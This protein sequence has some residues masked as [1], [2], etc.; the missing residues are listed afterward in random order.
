MKKRRL[1]AAMD[2]MSPSAD[3]FERAHELEVDVLLAVSAHAVAGQSLTDFYRRLA[4]TMGEL[5]G[6]DKV[7]FGRLGDDHMLTPLPGGPGVDEPFLSAMTATPRQHGGVAL[8]SRVCHAGVL[9][10]TL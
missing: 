2:D 6:A 9:F 1:L 5:V 10:L 8:A 3:P 4:R 7:L